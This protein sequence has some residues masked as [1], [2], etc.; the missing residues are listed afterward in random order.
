MLKSLLIASLALTVSMAPAIAQEKT[1]IRFG[2]SSAVD[3]ENDNGATAL[4]IKNYVESHSD[5]LKVDIYGSSELG[6]D[7]DV[8]QALQLGSG[9][10]MH[11]GGTATYNN[12]VPRVGVL[13]LP[14]LWKNYAHVGRALSGPTGVSL[15][16]DFE[17]AGFKVLGFG[18]S[19]GYRNVVTKGIAVTKP[20]DLR[21]L[22]LR[23]I[24]SPI[25]VA[26]LNAMGANATPMAFNEVYTALQTGVLDGFEHAASMVLSAKLY[27]V[28]DHMA[29]TR[30]LFG[31]TV[32]TYSLQLWNQLSEED[33]KVVQDAVDFSTEIARAM[34]PGREQQALDKLVEVGMT[35]TNVDTTEFVKAA[36]PLQDKLA[37]EINATDLLEAIRSAGE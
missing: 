16:A 33:Q 30:H 10:T 11:I 3:L 37:G 4:L 24:Q 1:T 2:F 26:A 32:V 8:I 35:I 22:K 18:Y 29:L 31:P 23:T 21:G 9:A 6:A 19:W 15:K 36:R 17:G 28:T 25:Y 20:S 5:T 27:E 7:Q 12:F 34:A 14:F 13:D